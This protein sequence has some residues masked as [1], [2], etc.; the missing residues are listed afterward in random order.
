VDCDTCVFTVCFDIA[1]N[2]FKYDSECAYVYK[3]PE[4]LEE[5]AQCHE[6][7]LCCPVEAVHNDGEG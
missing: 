7:F 6:A 3:Q 5:E 1:P 2:N 4:T